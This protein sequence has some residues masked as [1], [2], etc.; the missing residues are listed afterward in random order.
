M[1][2][3]CLSA[4][5]T[6]RCG[7]LNYERRSSGRMAC[8]L[9]LVRGMSERNYDSAESDRAKRSGQSPS[10]Y[11]IVAQIT[12]ISFTVGALLRHFRII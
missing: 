4:P 6:R 2:S 1:Q 5:A 10:E 8:F 12:A 7:R 11:V 9:A 3:R